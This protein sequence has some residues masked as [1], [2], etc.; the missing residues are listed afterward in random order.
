MAE[1]WIGLSSLGRAFFSG[2]LFFSTLFIWQFA[3]S[4]AG[5]GGDQGDVPQGDVEAGDVGA[6]DGNLI[7]DASGLATLRLFSIRSFLAFGM[8]FSWAGALYLT[9]GHTST[10]TL[11]R[12]LLW[13]LAGMLVVALFFWMLPRLAEEGTA[14][15]DTAIGA[16]GQVYMD[17]PERGSGQI[18]VTVSGA[19]SFIKARTEDGAPLVAGTAVRV[20]RRLDGRTLEIVRVES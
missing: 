14:N 18:R 11:I 3:A 5:L 9:Q 12:A 16:V 17:I 1:W 4:L 8:L 19:T 15:L 13:G 10:G 20:V 2:A 7:E 6:G